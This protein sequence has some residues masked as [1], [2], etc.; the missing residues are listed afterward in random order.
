[1]RRIAIIGAG[2]AGTLAAVGLMKR[3]YEVTLYS[4]RSSDDILDR[5]AP[6]GTA[7][8]FAD[9]I[10]CEAANGCDD[11]AD[12]AAKADSIHLN[13]LPKAGVE[14]VHVWGPL[15]DNVGYPVDLR[16]K[17]KRRMDQLEQGNA[18]VEIQAVTPDA[19]DGIAAQHDLT[20]V[21]TGKG[22]LAG[23]FERDPARSVYDRPQRQLAMIIVRGIPTE[24]SPFPH[25]LPGHVPV[26]FNFFGDMGEC[27]WTPYYHKTAGRCWCLLAEAKE[28]TKL[29]TFASARSAEAMLDA[30]RTLIKNNAPWDWGVMKDMELVPNDPLCWVA[31]SVTP[32]VRKPLGRTASGRLLMALGDT[33]Y[34]FDPI[35]GQGANCG[36]KQAAF[37]A[38]A[39]EARGDMPFDADWIAATGEAFY[40]QMGGPSYRFNNILLEPLDAVGRLVVISAFGHPKIAAEFFQNFNRPPDYFPWLA[41]RDAAREF[42]TR[43][44]GMSWRRVFARGL[45]RI[46]RGQIRQKLRGR[47][48]KYADE[49]LQTPA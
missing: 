27:F 36:S 1:M 44:T 12:V 7:F 29:H 6:T 25:R 48:F 40:Q 39:I 15:H 22:G 11:F 35:G 38:D 5:T 8:M 24:G 32:T 43:T 20:L 19:L 31:G 3:G 47:H 33:A 23:L 41:D 2:Q 16:L 4:D 18:R 26:S 28:G 14:L 45:L 34:A 17:S 13:F 37:Y 10:A 46:A 42:I 30:F 49:V 9:A 21:A